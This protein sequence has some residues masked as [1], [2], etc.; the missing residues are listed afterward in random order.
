MKNLNIGGNLKM[1]LR[2]IHLKKTYS[3]EHDDILYDFYIPV[4]QESIEY[5]RLAGFFSSTSLAIAAKG[6]LGLIKNGGNLKLIVAPKLTKKDLETILESYTE[7]PERYIENIM[8]TELEK[9]EDEFIRNHVFALG[10]LIANRKLEIKVAIPHNDEGFPLC[11]EE[12]QQRGLFHQKVGVLKDK[13]GN[14]ITFSGSINETASGWLENIEEFKVFR[15]WE[16]LEEEYVHADVSKFEKF[17]YNQSPKVRVIDIPNAVRRKLI[18]IA[19]NDIE[20]LD[21]LKWYKKIKNVELYQHQKNAVDAWF[22]N[23]MKGIFEMATGTGKTFAALGCLKKVMDEYEKI[24]AV[25][26]VPYNHLIKQWIKD[27]NEFGVSSDYIV[28]DSSN[29]DWKNNLADYLLDIKNGIKAKLIVI[30]THNT[31][32][33]ND[34]IKIIRSAYGKLLLIVDEVHSIGAPKRKEGL[35]EEYHFRLGLSATPK[36]WFDIEGTERLFDYFGGTVFEFTLGD[37][38]N[39]INPSTGESYLVPYEYKPYFVGLTGDELEKYETITKK[40]IKSYYNAKDDEEKENIFSLLCIQRQSIIKNAI[41]KYDA[42]KEILSEISKKE[43]IKHCLIY[44]A[45]E[46]IDKVQ[47]IL[48]NNNIIQHKFTLNEGIIPKPEY[49]GLSEREFLLR[50]FADGTYQVLVAI[51]CLDEGVDVP[52]AKIAIMLSSSGNPREWIQRL[53]RVL[54]RFPGKERAI[55]YDIIVVPWL[56]SDIDNTLLDMELKIFNKELT[57]YKDFAKLASNRLECLNRIYQLEQQLQRT[58]R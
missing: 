57:R 45:P 11:Y 37:A 55:I 7:A 20:K 4:L 22:R 56:L 48:N 28:A 18:E 24:I 34:F 3:S 33:S 1:S 36:R 15:N 53:G 5:D 19:P 21:L 8:V 9:L 51:R 42:L 31:F 25:V 29:P 44:C 14:I 12:V 50:K 17:W 54:R 10:W 23:N 43:K 47:D 41:K 27:M 38:I 13:D 32:A 30:T 40:I 39:S 2:T 52:P 46:Q 35:I 58:R 26:A 16:I 6:I 49:D